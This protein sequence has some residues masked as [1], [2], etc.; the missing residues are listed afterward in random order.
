MWA[1]VSWPLWNQCTKH[2]S[3]HLRVLWWMTGGGLH[4][5]ISRWEASTVTAQFPWPP[6][7]GRG[8]VTVNRKETIVQENCLKYF[9]CSPCKVEALFVVWRAIV[10]VWSGCTN[11]ECIYIY[12]LCGVL[13]YL[14]EHVLKQLR[15]VDKMGSVRKAQVLTFPRFIICV[16][17]VL[18][19]LIKDN[20]SAY[21]WCEY[22]S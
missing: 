2:S 12:L 13:S 7:Q 22:T 21:L 17:L 6:I 18:W 20:A 3:V 1:F 9:S 8:W 11:F 14:E 4:T 16:Q 19:V 5:A 10:T 15:Y